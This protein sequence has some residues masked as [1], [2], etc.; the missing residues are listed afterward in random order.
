MVLFL[1]LEGIVKTSETLGKDFTQF[2]TEPRIIRQQNQYHQYPEYFLIKST[3]TLTKGDRISG[4]YSPAKY[5]PE[6]FGI[7][8]T[9]KVLDELGKTM[10]SYN[11]DVHESYYSLE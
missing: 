7:V 3:F 4:T 5:G 6:K 8:K 2:Q 1:P 10:R 9:L 11:S